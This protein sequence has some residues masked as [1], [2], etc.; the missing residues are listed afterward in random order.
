M[1]HKI[2]STK[3]LNASV[4]TQLEQNGFMLIEKDFI[5]IKNAINSHSVKKIHTISD[6]DVVIFTSANAVEIVKDLLDHDINI[7][8]FCISGK[9]RES[10]ETNFPKATIIDVAPYGSELGKKIIATGI[11]RAIFFCGNIRRDELP[12]LLQQNNITVDEHIVYNTIQTPRQ[13]SECYD[14]IL[15]FSPSAVKS[16]F[17]VNELNSD[18]ICFSIG[19]TT[20]A[21]IE[22]YAGNKIII[23]ETPTQETLAIQINKHFKKMVQ[24]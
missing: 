6:G 13:I 5:A 17:A 20:A 12:A 7:K 16:F 1:G 11:R 4:K 10:I 15:F 21:E 14:A 22:K 9:T 23:A 8:V 24:S 2:L 18:A 19:T 3:T